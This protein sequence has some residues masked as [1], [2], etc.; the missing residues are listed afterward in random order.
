MPSSGT[1]HLSHIPSAS[2]S[3]TEQTLWGLSKYSHFTKA[4]KD[5]ASKFKAALHLP[6]SQ[7]EREKSEEVTRN[8][9]REEIDH[10][11]R[12]RKVREVEKEPSGE[13]KEEKVREA[14]FG[15]D[16]LKEGREKEV[17]DLRDGEG[18]EKVREAV[19]EEEG[20]ERMRDQTGVHV[21]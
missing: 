17:E 15:D 19:E 7:T 1:S 21:S 11:E 9:D 14:L 12:M 6:H 10:Q 20:R 2:N 5:L 16:G 4:N 13:G 3:L 8:A 18:E